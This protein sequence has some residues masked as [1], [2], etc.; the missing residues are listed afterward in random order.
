M[1]VQ[2]A[3]VLFQQF[4]D[5]AV[6]YSREDE[7]YFGLNAT[8]AAVWGLLGANGSTMDQLMETMLNLYPEAPESELRT[9]LSD[10]LDA[11]VTHGLLRRIAID[12][13]A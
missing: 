9:D 8:G 13:A 11:L 5:G 2:S 6:V 4:A 12:V 3:G 1:Y 10:L 7:S